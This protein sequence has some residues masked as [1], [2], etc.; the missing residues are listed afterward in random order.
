[1]TSY[2]INSYA[3]SDKPYID[4]TDLILA[5]ATTDITITYSILVDII[6]TDVYS[7]YT[8]KC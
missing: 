3:L 8:K 1:M 2:P 4:G 7:I 5:I 6:H